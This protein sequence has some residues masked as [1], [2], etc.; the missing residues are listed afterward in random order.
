MIKPGP[1][2]VAYLKTLTTVTAIASARI[3]AGKNLPAE[4]KIADGPAII[5]QPRGGEIHYSGKALSPSMQVRTFG[6][7]EIEAETL[8]GVVLDAFN[9]RSGAGFSWSYLEGVPTPLRDPDTGWDYQLGY[10]KIFI[11]N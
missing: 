5:I 7:N 10:F 9:N 3:Y 11:Q 1:I 8:M 6:K 4:F 2:C